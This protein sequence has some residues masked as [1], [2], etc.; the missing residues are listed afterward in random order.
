MKKYREIII[1]TFVDNA[2][3]L[4]IVDTCVI[5]FINT[6]LVNKVA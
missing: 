4:L 1:T 3:R 2:I 6:I 5:A